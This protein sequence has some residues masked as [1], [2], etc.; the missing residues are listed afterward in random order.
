[1]DEREAIRRC[2]SGD[3]EAFAHLVRQYQAQVL[4]LCYRMTGSR[5]DAA[6]IAQQAFLK[7]YQHLHTHDPAL[8]FR[9]WLLKIATNEC[10]SFLRRHGRQRAVP[11]EAVLQEAADPTPSPLALMELADDRAEVR[12]AV[13]ALPLPYRT[14]ILQYYFEGLSYQEIANRSG[15]AIGTISTHLFRAKQLLKRIL[16]QQEVRLA[17]AAR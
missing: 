16:T 6:D 15:M 11:D 1:L 10:V 8:P 5:E 14:V 3:R 17:H 4:G 12:Q 13:L 9:P 7:A 2:L